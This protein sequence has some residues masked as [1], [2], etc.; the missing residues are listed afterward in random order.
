MYALHPGLIKSEY[1]GDI[2]HIPAGKLAMLYKIKPGNWI[3]WDDSSPR[4][5]LGRNWDDYTHLFPRDDG[6]YNLVK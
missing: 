1:D 4:A 3:I 2:H 6:N 5:N